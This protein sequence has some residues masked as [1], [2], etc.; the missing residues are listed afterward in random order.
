MDPLRVGVC[1]EDG[2]GFAVV[3]DRRI[4]LRQA[5]EVLARQGHRI[6]PISHASLDPLLADASFVFDRMVSAYLAAALGMLD[7]SGLA[8]LEPL[9]CAVIARGSA[10]TATD[11]VMAEHKLAM[12]A[13]AVWRLFDAVDVLLTP[14]LTTPPPLVGSF[15]TDDSNV[16]A[17]WRRMH[18]FAPYASIA[19]V[20]GVPA[21]TIPHGV[22]GSGL[23]LPVQLIG[24]MGS[25]GL[26]LR[27]AHKLQEAQPW[28]FETS[29]AGLVPS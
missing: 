24:P 14:M 28:R 16:E 19:N 10:L 27:L 7:A 4:A 2:A 23:P 8:R 12:T 17:Q 5:T 13:H 11:L 26:L 22:D 1:L 9:T 3:E 21:L 6:V 25:D 15:P 20:A 29:V 18:A